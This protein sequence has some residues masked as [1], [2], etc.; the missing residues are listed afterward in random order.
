MRE[1]TVKG[2]YKCEFCSSVVDKLYLKRGFKRW[3]CRFCVEANSTQLMYIQLNSQA[4]LEAK[5][6]AQ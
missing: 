1:T 3:G 5:A 6:D 4:L 2:K